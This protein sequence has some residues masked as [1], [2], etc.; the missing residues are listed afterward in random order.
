MAETEKGGARRFAGSD[1]RAPWDRSAGEPDDQCPKW[2]SRSR[3]LKD[4][5]NRW[6]SQ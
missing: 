6:S 5:W 1:P 2:I 4:T 3:V